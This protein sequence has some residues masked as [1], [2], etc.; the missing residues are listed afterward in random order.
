MWGQRTDNKVRTMETEQTYKT[1]TIYKIITEG[2]EEGRTMRT[3]G[4]AMGNIEDI[5]GFYNDKRIYTLEITP[6]KVIRV[7]PESVRKKQELTDERQRLKERIAT[8]DELLG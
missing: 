8:L 3:L 6:I 1:G 4:Y 5:K 2:D 7:T